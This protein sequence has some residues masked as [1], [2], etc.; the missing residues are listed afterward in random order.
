MD[1]GGGEPRSIIYKNCLN[2]IVEIGTYSAALE[3]FQNLL[4]SSG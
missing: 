2:E 1:F 3:G 4:Y